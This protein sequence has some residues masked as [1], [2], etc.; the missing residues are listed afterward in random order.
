MTWLVDPETREPM[1]AIPSKER[2][3]SYNATHWR[4][5]WR[6]GFH[7]EDGIPVRMWFAMCPDECCR[8]INA[9]PITYPETEKES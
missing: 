6:S 5:G 4:P 8:E 7:Y 2:E 9:R 3:R 1:A